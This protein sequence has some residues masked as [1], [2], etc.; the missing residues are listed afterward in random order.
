MTRLRAQVLVAAVTAFLVAAAISMFSVS[1]RAEGFY[2]SGYGG[3]N[4]TTNLGGAGGG[5][6]YKFNASPDTGYVIGGVLGTDIG[7]LPGLR[8]EADGS[9]RKNQLS[10]VWSYFVPDGCCVEAKILD[11]PVSGTW[12]DNPF[13]GADTTFALMGNLVYGVQ[14]GDFQ[15][16]VLGGIGYGTRHLQLV[17]QTH[18]NLDT[19][20]SSFVWQAGAG[21]SYEVAKNVHVSVDYRYFQGP[22]I[23]RT[24]DLWETPVT[25]NSDGENQSVTAAVTFG[26][27]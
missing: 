3:A 16:Y 23:T 22:S 8:I 17:S 4:W 27:N 10:G 12:V 18:P 14:L 21:V 1:A 7:A 5:G 24:V 19:D 15:P 25:F 6:D 9:Y 20:E 26:F 11:A 2:V 13:T